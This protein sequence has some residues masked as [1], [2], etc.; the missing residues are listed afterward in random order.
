MISRF[1]GTLAFFALGFPTLAQAAT[2]ALPDHDANIA[3]PGEP[4][5]IAIRK[6]PA[7]SA[8]TA[9]AAP[10]L[11]LRAR[12][13]LGNETT[14][15]LAA[16][17]PRTTTTRPDELHAQFTPPWLGWMELTLAIN[18]QP[19]PAPAATTRL[20]VIPKTKSPG[21]HFRYG[22]SDHSMSLGG[23][24]RRKTLALLDAL[25]VDIAR[26]EPS[27]HRIKTN[28]DAPWDFTR[29]DQML[30][31]YTA[32]GIEMQAILNYGVPWATTATD[33]RD[34]RRTMPQMEPWLDYVRT[35][36][37]RYKDRVRHWEIWN[38]PDIGF[39]KSTTAQYVGL[40]NRTS[41]EIARL[42]PEARI[43]NGGF[44]MVTRQPNP[45]FVEEFIATADPAHWHLRAWHDYNTFGQLLERH[46][47]HQTLYKKHARSE[48]TA[49]PSWMNEGGYHTIDPRDEA[50]Q[51]RAIVKKVSTAPALGLAAYFVYTTRDSSRDRNGPTA[52]FYGLADYDCLP[53]PA[54]AAYNRLIAETA[55]LRYQPPA[56]TPAGSAVTNDG[57]WQHLYAT[58]TATT[59]PASESQHHTLV[60]WREGAGRQSPVWLRW[61]AAR[62]TAILDLMGNPVPL[63]P[64]GDGVVV[65]LGDNP[66]YIHLAGI[67]AY[68]QTTPILQLPELLSIIPGARPATLAISIHNPTTSSLSVR[69]QLA[70]D[71]PALDVGPPP[72][73]AT[74]AP[75]ATQNHHLP[76]VLKNSTAASLPRGQLTLALTA[77]GNNT[78]DDNNT[79]TIKASLPY[80]AARLLS[81][82][83]PLI[84][85]LHNRSDIRNLHEALANPV[86]EWKGPDDLSATATWTTT[87]DAL[88]LTVNV[89]DQTHHQPHQRDTLWQA[90]SLQFA[91]RADD[92]QTGCLEL[93]LALDQT[94]TPRGWIMS[95][96][97]W[98]LFGKGDLEGRVPFTATRDPA[99]SRTTYQLTLPWRALGYAKQPA[100]A[101]RASFIVNDDDGL[102]RKQYLQLSPGIGESKD[103]Q[104]Y[105]LFLCRP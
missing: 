20:A 32:R 39:W 48:T 104:K 24:T 75:G 12:D 70:S 90:D 94:A 26:E 4:V 89:T 25:G 100:T 103:P 41:A 57:L 47:Q 55:H 80:E 69:L 58:P 99:T 77:T 91:F 29:P 31:D 1:L 53:K 98:T 45:R 6:L 46:N 22:I 83:A 15:P 18:G 71:N 5:T 95:N 59:S 88:Q 78:R 52:P 8:A 11:A 63:N 36:V 51:A 3:P 27:W 82:R 38:E 97:E 35:T 23:S 30:A 10:T 65:N 42:Q 54:Y 37:N 34:A 16:A 67:P 87:P 92:T 86:M 33:T 21:T 7:Q 2:L 14:L 50:E 9:A 43:M 56:A 102:G 17:N 96:P 68:P 44:A 28:A 64:L 61:P 62:A 93:V 105:P 60:T 85:E 73:P 40:F 101:W 81:S 13:W 74:L 72:P 76:V 84:T 19:D 66:L 49:L 79:S